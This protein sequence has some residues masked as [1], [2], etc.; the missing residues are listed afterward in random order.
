M[1]FLGIL[2][3][4]TEKKLVSISIQKDITKIFP[5]MLLIVAFMLDCILENGKIIKAVSCF[6]G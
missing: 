6:L 3:S 1:Q 5:K 2:T 4:W